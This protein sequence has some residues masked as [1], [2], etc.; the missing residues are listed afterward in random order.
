MSSFFNKVFKFIMTVSAKHNIDSTHDMSHSLQVLQ[1]ASKI[2]EREHL[3]F[4]QLKEHEA[5]IYS[6]AA[7]HDMC[8]D[9]YTD[10]EE[11]KNDTEQFLKRE[12]VGTSEIKVI[13]DII[14]T[15]SYSKVRNT[16]FPYH[17]EYQRAYNV[18]READLMA[19]YDF[20]R[21]MLFKMHRAGTGDIDEAFRDA[22]EL[23]RTRVFRHKIDGLLTTNY[24]F[25][26][27]DVLVVSARD[28][29]DSWRSV[30]PRLIRPVSPPPPPHV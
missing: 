22:E 6:A 17:G 13:M 16:G 30:I 15:M 24:A 23:F 7:L 27:H 10:V 9:K 21:C 5:I 19:A 8:D 25:E 3:L 11:G 18:V 2:Y 20:D 14:D 1:Y 4:P 26:Q 28:R 12:N 29:I